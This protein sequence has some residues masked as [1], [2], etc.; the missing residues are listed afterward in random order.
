MAEI[1][2]LSVAKTAYDRDGFAVIPGVF[3]Q[4]EVDDIR[5]M[6]YHEIGVNPDK[7]Q[8]L[9]SKRPALLSW[10]DI[11][12]GEDPRMKTIVEHFLGANVR[13]LVHQVYFREAGDGDQF[14]WHQDVIFR[15]PETDFAAIDSNYLQTIIVIDQMTP[16]GGA[17]EFVPGS[18]KLGELDLIKNW[19]DPALRRFV[20][21]NWR[22]VK[23]EAYPGDVVLWSPLVM[24]GS[25]PNVTRHNRMTY[26][27][28]FAAES[29]IVNKEKF[30]VYMWDGK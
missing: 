3:T 27:S 14:A 29:A 16:D 18:H 20:R 19:T 24:H 5:H 12:W 23:L 30:P 6:A 4:A 7:V 1:F 8:W 17:I 11:R 9:N 26:M 21:G 2:S 25:E 28:G 10:P 13:R 22:G 15:V